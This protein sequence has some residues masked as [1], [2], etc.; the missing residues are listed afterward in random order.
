MGS[1]RVTPGVLSDVRRGG[2]RG[3][4]VGDAA[5]INVD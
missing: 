4:A 5:N 2:V 3:A 1:C